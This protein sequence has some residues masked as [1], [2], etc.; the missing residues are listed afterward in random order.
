MKKSSGGIERLRGIAGL[1][2][3]FGAGQGA[4]FLAQSWLV[5]R[6]ELAFVGQVGLGL[7]G[8]SLGQLVADCG[9]IFILSRHAAQRQSDG[10]FASAN[11]I[12]SA[13]G[14]TAVLILAAVA[15]YAAGPIERAVVLGG[16]AS[17][18]LWA[19]N[20]AGMLDGLG[21]S[22]ISGPISSFSWLFAALGLLLFDAD[23]PEASGLLIGLLFTVGTALTI[24][25]QYIIARRLGR[26]V[27]AARPSRGDMR[28]FMREGGFFLLA[29]V[30]GQF[31]GRSLILV[32]K[33]FLGTDAA[34]A[35]VYARSIVTAAT[36]AITF[37]RRVEFPVLAHQLSG[38]K[39]K[40]REML[41]LQWWSI[42]GSILYLMAVSGS[43]LL[44]PGSVLS[45]SSESIP[46]ALL[47]LSAPIPLWAVSSS[48]Q[49]AFLT[50]GN[51][52]LYAVVGNLGLLVAGTLILGTIRHLGLFAIL[53][54]EVATYGIQTI[55]Y[56]WFYRSTLGAVEQVPN[57]R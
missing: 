31:Y 36:Q 29:N 9:G 56:L 46:I 43:I 41:G 48:F 28:A 8:L 34:G 52:R 37:V 50:V 33:I 45:G 26:R 42:G 12:R 14:I 38:G 54:G 57:A 51:T 5:V 25:C 32:A 15:Y 23:R 40:I 10:Y 22:E 11:L 44:V 47:C 4:M 20:L 39:L 17:I 2:L 19:I 6:G 16:V 7:A 27:L 35:V 1:I 3:G 49:Q 53:W 24:I 55:V 13:F 18:S 21:R 30:P